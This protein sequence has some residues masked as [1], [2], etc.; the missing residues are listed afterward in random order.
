MSPIGA[1]D[2]KKRSTTQVRTDDFSMIG[3][4]MGALLTSAIFLKRAPLPYLLL[5]GA[6]IGLGAGVWVHLAQAYK[7]GNDVRPEGMVSHVVT[8]LM[9]GWGD[10]GSWRQYK[11]MYT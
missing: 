10:S 4:T 9:E 8:E 11:M 5:G 6:S 3:A 2:G 7:E 1:V